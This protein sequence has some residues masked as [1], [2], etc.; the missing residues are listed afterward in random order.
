MVTTIRYTIRYYKLNK[1]KKLQLLINYT[2]I[3]IY[4]LTIEMHAK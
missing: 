1:H 4:I 3:Y 2:Y